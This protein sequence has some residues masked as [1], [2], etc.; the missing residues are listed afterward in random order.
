MARLNSVQYAHASRATRKDVQQNLG[1][2]DDTR[3]LAILELH[4]SVTQ[5]EEA[6]AWATGQG[7]ILGRE[8]RPLEGVVAETFDI[9]TADEEEEPP[10]PHH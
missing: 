8:N 6:L 1:D 2:M 3:A 9:L 10:L 7:D 4:P 5:I